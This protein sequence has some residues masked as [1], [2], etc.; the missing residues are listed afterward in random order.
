MKHVARL[1]LV[2]AA[3]AAAAVEDVG[4][5]RRAYRA[6]GLFRTRSSRGCRSSAAPTRGAIFSG[7]GRS[8][9]EPMV[10]G[11]PLSFEQSPPLLSPDYTGDFGLRRFLVVGDF[12]TVQFHRAD[13]DD[14]THIE[15]WQRTTTTTI[16]SRVV[17]VFDP[18]WHDSDLGTVLQHCSVG[19]DNPEVYW[20][21]FIVPGGANVERPVWLR[22]TF[23]SVPASP[24]R[25]VSDQVQF[26]SNVVNIV[27]PDF[28][29]S[30]VTAG[31][32]QYNSA[33]RPGCSTS[34]SPTN[35]RASRSSP[36][37]SAL[38][39]FSA[40]HGNV[41]NAVTGVGMTTV[42]QTS[43][44]GSGGTLQGVELFGASYLAVNAASTHEFAHQWGDKFNWA[45][46]AGITTG[47]PSTQRAC[48]VVVGRGDD[49]GRGAERGSARDA[50][51]QRVSDRTDARADS[52]PSDRAL[53][54][55]ADRTGRGARSHRL[56]G[57]G[58]VLD[59]VES[60]PILARRSRATAWW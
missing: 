56:Q 49:A 7:S 37:A 9:L 45:K 44:Y 59:D 13:V 36:V 24:V 5:P 23:S 26:A 50:E 15:T 47:G 2:C 43:V 21:S 41:K 42:D 33:Q 30:R 40:F 16:G 57:P 39:D 10:D 17:S 52:L 27:V 19:Y 11:Q 48:A 8:A 46:I 34:R 51:R 31:V 6:N 29:D 1:A 22:M 4:S 53:L 35:T 18:V 25:R 14:P 55:G 58:T 60:G 28:E 54:D 20:G 3:A 32:Q 38:G 12:A